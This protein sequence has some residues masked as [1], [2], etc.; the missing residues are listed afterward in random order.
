MPYDLAVPAR[1]LQA[2]PLPTHRVLD[3]TR[4]RGD[5][6]YRDLVPAREALA[7]TAH[8]LVAHPLEQGA[9]EERVLTDPFD[10]DAEDRL[11]DAWQAA[12]EPAVDRLHARSPGTAWRTA[13][14]VGDRARRPTSTRDRPPTM[15]HRAPCGAHG[16]PRLPR[17]STRH[18]RHRGG[19]VRAARTP[20]RVRVRGSGEPVQHRRRERRARCD[21]ARGHVVAH[22]G[23]LGRCRAHGQL[24]GDGVRHRPTEAVPRVAPEP[25]RRTPGG[26][27]HHGGGH[28]RGGDRVRRA[29]RSRRVHPPLPGGSTARAR[30]SRRARGD[31]A[32]PSISPAAI[33]SSPS[34]SSPFPW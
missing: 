25:P 28:R 31:G 8:W 11:I 22:G 32:Y 23:E 24:R 27:R 5:L 6:G 12:R 19:G 20:R 10:Y 18:R 21:R 4:L 34:S 7:R 9:Q 29:S 26:A 13:A 16:V 2:Q 1:P 15:G 17:A 14:P 30:R 33:C 3:L